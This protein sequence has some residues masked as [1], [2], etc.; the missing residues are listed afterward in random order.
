MNTVFFFELVKILG[1]PISATGKKQR[2][3]DEKQ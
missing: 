2:Q 1:G 3:Y